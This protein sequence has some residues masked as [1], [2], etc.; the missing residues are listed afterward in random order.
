MVNI[1]NMDS[2]DAYF[3]LK[4]PNYN[5]LRRRSVEVKVVELDHDPLVLEGGEGE[6]ALPDVLLGVEEH[7]R[8]ER[9][10][11]RGHVRR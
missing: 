2:D 1:E 10:V 11:L 4:V 3:N 9:A 6:G 8:L 7:G 5:S